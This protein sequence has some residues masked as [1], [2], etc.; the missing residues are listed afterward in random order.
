VT[1]IERGGTGGKDGGRRG[2]KYIWEEDRRV[3]KMRRGGCR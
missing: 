3:I 2:G 1:E